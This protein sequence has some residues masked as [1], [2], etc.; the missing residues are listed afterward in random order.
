MAAA[1]L[2]IELCEGIHDIADLEPSTDAFVVLRFHGVPVGHVWM[3][4]TDGRLA[5]GPLRD[6]A[7][8]AAL[9][10][11]SRRWLERGSAAHP[12]RQGAVT[13]DVTIAIC[14]H[15]RPDELTAVLD[16][17]T[18]IASNYPILVIDNRPVTDGTRRVVQRFANVHYVREDSPGLNAARNRALREATTAIVAFTDDDAAPE[19][20]WAAAL[21][22]NFDHPLVLAVTGLTLPRELDTPAQIW[23]ERMS[24]FGRGYFRREFVPLECS[25]HAAGQAGAG[26]NMAIRRD[27]VDL[28][29]GFDERLDAGTPTRSGGDH[30]MFARILA[31]GYRLVYEPAAV[32]RHRHRRAWQEL[33]H[34]LHGYGVGVYAAW[35]GQIIER[36]QWSVLRQ[37]ALWAWRIQL[38]VLVRSLLRTRGAAPLD[39]VLAE[40]RGCARGPFAWFVS[41]RQR[42]RDA[43]AM[44][45]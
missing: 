34:T 4:V 43:R 21:A 30:E 19:A 16:A 26:A 24:G 3:P 36:G 25:P 35:T 23:F 42:I 45:A 15:E 6:R 29:G 39:L 17:L 9:P 37:A 12:T 41:R 7:I 2:D 33:Q 22:R 44:P 5:A 8:A 20:G 13:T 28:V 11:L 32:S 1:V 31:G 10:A 14:T 40:L 18:R 38:P 27:V